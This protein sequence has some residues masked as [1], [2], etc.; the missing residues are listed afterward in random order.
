M[1]VYNKELDNYEKIQR[2][3]ICMRR[4]PNRSIETAGKFLVRRTAQP[5]FCFRSY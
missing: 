3:A 2:A 5:T 1:I 4:R